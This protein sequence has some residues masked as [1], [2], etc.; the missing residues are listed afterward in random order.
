MPSGV[1]TR[2]WTSSSQDLPPIRSETMPAVMNIRF[3][4]WYLLLREAEGSR[5]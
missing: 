4:Y 5:W 1:R 2:S 3:W